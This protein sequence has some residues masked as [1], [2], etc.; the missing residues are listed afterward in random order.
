MAALTNAASASLVAPASVAAR[1]GSSRRAAFQGA[2]VPSN[3]Q[4]HEE[5]YRLFVHGERIEGTTTAEA[6]SVSVTIQLNFVDFIIGF[7]KRVHPFLSD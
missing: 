6:R 3:V 4:G 1:A 7:W 2:R 5:E